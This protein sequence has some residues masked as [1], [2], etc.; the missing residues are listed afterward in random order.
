MNVGALERNHRIAKAKLRV[1]IWCPS[2]QMSKNR[3][4]ICA[5]ASGAIKTVQG[6]D[7][8]ILNCLFAI[9]FNVFS[10]EPKLF[11][12]LHVT[13]KKSLPKMKKIQ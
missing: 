3:E 7:G 13:V 2:C 9:F 11:A 8:F 10:F 4:I 1:E 12:S 6:V 5:H